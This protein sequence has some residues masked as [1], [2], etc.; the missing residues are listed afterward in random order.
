MLPNKNNEFDMLL[1]RLEVDILSGLF[2]PR[3]RLIE[4]ELIQRYHVSRGTIRNALKELN[5]NHLIELYPNRGAIVAEHCAK[6]MEDIFNARILLEGFAIKNSIGNIDKDAL[7][8]IHSLEKD[9]EREVEKKNLRQIVSLNR[10]FHQSIFDKCGNGVI[11]E[12]ID[13]LRKRSHIWQHYVA[14]HPER[15]ARTIDE[16]RLIVACIKKGDAVELKNIN[17]KHLSEGYKNYREDLTRR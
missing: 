15:L 12:I 4:S 10:L 8:E 16:H 13:Q 17:E 1:E 7:N 2:R 5:F 9:F 11:A 14:G 6:E 3:E